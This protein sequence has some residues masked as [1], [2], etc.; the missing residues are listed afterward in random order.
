MKID[1]DSSRFTAKKGDYLTGKAGDLADPTLQQ[2]AQEYRRRL[3]AAMKP[4][5]AHD[6]FNIPKSRGYY[7]MRKYDGEFTYVLFDGKQLISVNPGGTVRVGLPCFEEAVKLLKKAK[8]GSCI[9]AGELYAVGDIGN[10]NRVQEIVKLLRAPASEAALKKIGLA[11]FDIVE[12]EG[13][14]VTGVADVFKLLDKWFAKGKLVHSAEHI[15]TDKLDT[16]METFTEWVIGEA[17]EGL[18]VRHDSLGWYKIKLRHNLD[19]AI[20]GYSEGTENRKGTLH[21]LLVAVM[22]SDG[23]F[24]ELA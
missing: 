10:R 4:L 24:H 23:T 6:V 12:F 11:L 17:S 5:A 14:A 19:A 1:F 3:S 2:K 15:V 13:K 8:V 16:V 22:R 18:V 21:D 7:A 20:I 9:L